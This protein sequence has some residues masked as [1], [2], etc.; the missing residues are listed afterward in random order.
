MKRLFLFFSLMTLCGCHSSSTL[1]NTHPPQV[2][3]TSL[4]SEIASLDPRKGIDMSSQ[5]VV[6]MLFT[7][8][9][10]LDDQMVPQLELA[11]SYQISSD[12]KTYLFT[13]KDV[14]WSDGSPITAHD[15]EKTWKAALFPG[16][17]SANTNL[18]SF[19]KNGKKATLGEIPADQLGVKA[20]DDKTLLIELEDPNPHFLNVLI[21]SIFSPVHESMYNTPPRSDHL[22]CSGPFCL[23]EHAFQN[24]ITLVRNPHY[25][26]ASN[27]KLD[28]LHFYIIK[29]PQ[30]ALLMF[31]KQQLDWLGEPLTR[32]STDAIPALKEKGLLTFFSAA[33]GQWLFL[34]TAKFPLNN[35]QIRKALS[36]AIDRQKILRNLMHLDD[37]NLALGLIPRILKKDH[38]HPWFQ[39][40]D[41]QQAQACFA[42]GLKEL[43]TTVDQLPKLTMIYPANNTWAKI[44]EAIQQMWEQN[45]GIKIQLEASDGAVYFQK[46]FSN[47]YEIARLGWVIQYNDPV[48]LL[49]IFKYK[50]KKPNHTGWENPEFIRHAD[51]SFAATSELERWEHIEAAEKIFSDEMPSIPLTDIVACYLQQPYVKGVTVNSLYHIDFHYAWLEKEQAAAPPAR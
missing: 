11:K 44:L 29:D 43:N 16:Y 14:L 40:N 23:K 5:G 32:I 36:Y 48:N 50:D 27:V 49:E 19:I 42:Q 13:L 38:W 35:P 1:K 9:V 25:W 12:Y 18:F 33:G 24:Q 7:G 21:N 22:I 4:S 2:L 28:E 46:C 3:R 8:L 30:T 10:R 26:N 6:R 39:D 17:S 51:A 45:L 37:S 31:E 20:L 41:V 34:N 15:F 47:Q